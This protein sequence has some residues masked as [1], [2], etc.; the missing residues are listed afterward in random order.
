M[1]G[2][3]PRSLQLPSSGREVLHRLEETEVGPA[4]EGQQT[5]RGSLVVKTNMS[6]GY[7][8][9]QLFLVIMIRCYFSLCIINR[10]NRTLPYGLY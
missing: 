10:D 8:G 5:S 2:D 1:P 7:D 6:I 4:E 3:P 9:L